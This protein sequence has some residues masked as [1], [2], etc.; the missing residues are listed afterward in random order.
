LVQNHRDVVVK[1]QRGDVEQHLR[2][3]Y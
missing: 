2:V 1:T 3:R